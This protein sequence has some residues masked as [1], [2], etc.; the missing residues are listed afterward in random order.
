[1]YRAI[2]PQYI[3]KESIHV[4]TFVIEDLKASVQPRIALEC[5]SSSSFLND[6]IRIGNIILKKESMLSSSAS[7]YK[8]AKLHKVDN[9]KCEEASEGASWERNSTDWR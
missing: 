1:M 5:S 2:L 4:S 8:H 9:R 7:G 3:P 6:Q